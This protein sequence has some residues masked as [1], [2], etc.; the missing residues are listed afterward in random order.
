MSKRETCPDCQ[1]TK[2]LDEFWRL[3]P[4]I[5]KKAGR[6]HSE[7]CRACIKASRKPRGAKSEPEPESTEP[8]TRPR[9]TVGLALGFDV[10]LDGHDFH[11]TQTNGDATTTHIY[12][13]HE[14]RVLWEFAERQAAQ[15]AAA[16]AA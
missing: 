8:D 4:P 11:V 7:R 14:L 10:V 13:A 5:A 16:A 1:K 12:G 6:T 3:S 9:L 15:Q 2:S